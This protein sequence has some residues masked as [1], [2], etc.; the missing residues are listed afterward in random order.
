MRLPSKRKV[1]MRGQADHIEVGQDW[2]RDP[3]VLAYLD[4][5]VSSRCPLMEAWEGQ[6]ASTTPERQAIWNN[7]P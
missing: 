7:R 4:P 5:K 6:T 1:R 3:L 2:N